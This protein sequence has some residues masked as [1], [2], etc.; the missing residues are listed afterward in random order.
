MAVTESALLSARKS[1]MM[2]ALQTMAYATT[3]SPAFE[4]N[5]TAFPNNRNEKFLALNGSSKYATFDMNATAV[6]ASGV[7]SI[8]IKP[9]FTPTASASGY[10]F[11]TYSSAS[12]DGLWLDFRSDIDDWDAA[13]YNDGAYVNQITTTGESWSANDCIHMVYMWNNTAGLDNS[14]A[15]A[16]YINNSLKTTGTTTWA[17]IGDYYS[18]T[19][20]VGVRWDALAEFFNGGV[21]DFAV[22]DYA[23]LASSYT[24]AEIVQA[25]YSNTFNAGAHKFNFELGF[26]NTVTIV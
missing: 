2:S 17:T 16:L 19:A 3:G 10:I 26:R 12:T 7:I 24:D 13:V 4:A 18:T 23:S 9:Y 22:F 1:M 11:N 5:G 8:W 25:L 20:K 6:L 15:L 14:K 21:F